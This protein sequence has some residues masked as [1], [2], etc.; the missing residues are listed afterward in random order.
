M[1]HPDFSFS[2]TVDAYNFDYSSDHSIWAIALVNYW[3]THTFK[4]ANCNSFCFNAVP[5]SLSPNGTL[6]VV[7]VLND[8]H[9]EIYVSNN[10]DICLFSDIDAQL[11]C[12]FYPHRSHPAQFTFST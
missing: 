9:L 11:L 1:M 8:P 4:I 5:L 12:M 10:E 7:M 6:H 2:N 3:V